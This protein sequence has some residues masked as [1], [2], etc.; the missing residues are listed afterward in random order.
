MTTHAIPTIDEPLLDAREI[1][2]AIVP[3]FS[4]PYQTYLGLR[5]ENVAKTKAWLTAIAGDISTLGEVL[6]GRVKF[7]AIKARIKHEAAQKKQAIAVTHIKERAS[8]ELDLVHTSI[9]FSYPALVKLSADAQSFESDAF[10]LGLVARSP[11][12]GDPTDPKDEGSPNNWVVG[13]PG[14]VADILMVVAADTEEGRGKKVAEISKGASKSGL[15]VIYQEDAAVLPGHLRGHEHFGFHDNV[16]QPGV[17]GRVAIDET[18][19]SLNPLAVDGT[20]SYLNPR[21]ISQEVIP[22]SMLYGIPGQDLVWPGEFIIGYPGQ[23]QD[24]L[25]PGN[26]YNLFP[27]W[28]KNGSFLVFR[29]LRQYVKLFWE[30]MTSEAKRLSKTAGFKGI[31]PVAFAA[32]IVG[33]WPSGAPF[34]RVQDHD[35]PALGEEG[36]LFNNHFRYD[37]DTCPVRLKRGFVDKYPQAKA[38][39]VGLTCPMTAHIRKVNTR[40]GANDTGGTLGTYTRRI[41]RRGLPFGSPLVEGFDDE[42]VKL[43]EPDPENGNRGLLF[44]GYVGSLE[45]QYEFLQNRWMANRSAPRSPGGDDIMIGLNGNVGQ[46]RV[47]QGVVFGSNLKAETIATNLPWLVPTGGGY[48]FTPSISAIRDVLA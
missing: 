32:R 6:T 34:S 47:R 10:R 11:F 25:I 1:Q 12:L 13:A 14:N 19:S 9:S 29:R 21:W 41:I 22:D 15:T 5:I 2:G 4:K 24:P 38:D 3:G 23:T 43:K 40:D 26:P 8:T 20:E 27:T 45:D 31:T 42:Q 48:Y 18:G 7:R 16:S 17:R 37:A 46:E 39:P 30:F 33:R 28:S 36:E 35:D 44:L